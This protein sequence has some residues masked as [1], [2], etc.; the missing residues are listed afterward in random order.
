MLYRLEVKEKVFGAV[1]FRS[2]DEATIY[3]RELFKKADDR[4][5]RALSAKNFRV[6]NTIRQVREAVLKDVRIV[7]VSI[8]SAGRNRVE[9][10]QTNRPAPQSS[11]RRHYSEVA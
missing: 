3:L 1:T 2:I 4:Y 6:A 8:E 7:S 9:S 10:N 5:I 11:C